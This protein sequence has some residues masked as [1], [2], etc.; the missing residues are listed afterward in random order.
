MTKRWYTYHLLVNILSG[1]SLVPCL[2][3]PRLLYHKLF[4]RGEQNL[5]QLL[6]VLGRG[7]REQEAPDAHGGVHDVAG[8]QHA[9][10]VPLD[11]LEVEGSVGIVRLV[12]D[13]E[14]EHVVFDAIPHGGVVGMC[15]F[16]VGLHWQ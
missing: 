1:T 2:M 3:V 12:Q 16:E 5:M 14:A 6:F 8:L 11:A 4:Q 13:D 15:A 7:L 10:E 9:V